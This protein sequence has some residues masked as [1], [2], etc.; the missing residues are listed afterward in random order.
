MRYIQDARTVWIADSLSAKSGSLA[1]FFE[2]D[3]VIIGFL[4][5]Q[6]LYSAHR[7]PGVTQ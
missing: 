4:K 5:V 7:E 2:Q 3:V 6:V 1:V